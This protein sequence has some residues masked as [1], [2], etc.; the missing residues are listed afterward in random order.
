M[1]FV[2]PDPD[3]EHDINMSSYIRNEAMNFNQTQHFDAACTVAL[4]SYTK[5]AAS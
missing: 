4:L 5:I 3:S 1:I 2:S